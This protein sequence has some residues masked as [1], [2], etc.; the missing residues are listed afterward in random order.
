[1][2]AMKNYLLTLLENCSEEKFG[3]DAVEW[4]IVCGHVQL[5]Y[6]LDTD[7][8][9]IMDPVSPQSKVQSPQSDDDSGLKTADCGLTRYDQIIEA[10]QR[11]CREQRDA[12]VELYQSTGLLEEILRPVRAADLQSV[13]SAAA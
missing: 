6:D 11:H 12:L 9:L 4:A 10:Y 13:E 5:T 2:G 8:R 1:M 3:Q 7:L